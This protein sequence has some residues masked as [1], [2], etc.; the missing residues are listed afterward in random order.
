MELSLLFKGILHHWFVRL[1]WHVKSVLVK[2]NVVS[3]GFDMTSKSLGMSVRF[4]EGG[5][6]VDLEMLQRDRDDP[7]GRSQL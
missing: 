2:S 1:M 6:F 5:R 4:W 7:V 3:L